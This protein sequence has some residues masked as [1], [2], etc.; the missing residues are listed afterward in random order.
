MIKDKNREM[1][2][3][4]SLSKREINAPKK[5]IPGVGDYDIK[6]HFSISHKGV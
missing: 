3:Y 1:A 4:K 6:D 2:S 5:G